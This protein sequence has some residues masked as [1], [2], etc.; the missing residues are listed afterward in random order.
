MIVKQLNRDR[1]RGR[2]PARFHAAGGLARLGAD[3][4][5]DGRDRD[6]DSTSPDDVGK[7]TE[8]N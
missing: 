8:R 5:F 2:S 4:C 1:Y 7:T 6:G 3:S